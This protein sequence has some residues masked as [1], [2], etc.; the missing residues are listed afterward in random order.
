MFHTL[1]YKKKFNRISVN[2]PQMSFQTRIM[3]RSCSDPVV[4]RGQQVLV[5]DIESSPT[6]LV[7]EPPDEP[8]C[9][10]TQQS[11]EMGSYVQEV[12]REGADLRR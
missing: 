3:H 6:D 2:K 4:G 9:G 7:Y 1:F 11:R 12:Q 8:L 10:G 5:G